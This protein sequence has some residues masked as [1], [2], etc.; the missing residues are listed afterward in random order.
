MKLKEY[1]VSIAQSIKLWLTPAQL[2]GKTATRADLPLI[3][4]LTSIPSRLGILHLTIRSL[5]RQRLQPEKIILWLNHELANQIPKWL[6]N[7]QGDRFEIRFSDQ[8]C[9][10]RKLVHSL[11]AFPQHT[12]V[13]C[14]DDLIYPADWLER[15]ISEHKKHPTDIIGHECRHIAYTDN[16]EARPYK[17]WGSAAPGESGN[18]ILPIGYGGTLYPLGCLHAE[19]TNS[20]RYLALAPKADD[21]WFKAMSLRQ[22]TV[23]RRSSKPPKKPTPIIRS[24][25][26]RL[27]D[28]NI[29]R[30]GNR[31]QWQ[32]LLEAYP[33]IRPDVSAASL[34]GK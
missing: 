29:K 15:L 17:E 24:Q 21:L 6:A 4:S 16:G 5:L 20:E 1:P 26:V 11:N 34:V 22:G 25:Q 2:L 33:E 19:V 7:L 31:L 23:S 3:V 28:T 32:A 12:I 27:G 14:D 9:A 18:T 13:T 30:D 8:H 10:H